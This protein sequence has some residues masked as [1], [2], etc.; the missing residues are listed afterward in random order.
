VSEHCGAG[1]LTCPLCGETGHDWSCGIAVEINGKALYVLS[2]D[3]EVWTSAGG[4][5]FV[6]LDC[7][8]AVADVLAAGGVA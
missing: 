7:A 6:C 5:T 4:E 1:D 8:D 2:E 3:R